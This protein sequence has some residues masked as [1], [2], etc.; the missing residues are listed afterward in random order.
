[1]KSD[2][3]RTIRNIAFLEHLKEKNRNAFHVCIVH[4][5]LWCMYRPIKIVQLQLVRCVG[6]GV[7]IL[8]ISH[9]VIMKIMKSIKE[10]RPN[11]GKN[12]FRGRP[13]I[14]I[15]SIYLLTYMGVFGFGFEATYR[16]IRQ[17][18]YDKW[19]LGR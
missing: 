1:M 3:R 10:C 18:I 4:K 8:L 5:R 13:M 6:G 17:L 2:I 14:L 15:L 11:S 12:A 19:H 16:P 9:S 7:N